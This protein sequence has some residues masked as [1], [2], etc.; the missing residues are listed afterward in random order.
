MTIPQT[1]AELLSAINSSYDRLARDLATIPKHL[2][3]DA[4]LEGHA[5][6]SMMSVRDLVSYL[7]GWNE[8]VL[9]WH[10]RKRAGET[11]DFPETGFKWNELGKLAQKFYGDYADLP[12][13]T[14]LERLAD[15][16]ARIVVLVESYSDTELYGS[17]WY[18][19]YAMGR[20]IQFNSSA[21]YA[22]ARGRLRKW[23]KTKGLA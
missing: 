23:K 8:L 20:M 13:P 12:F 21:P 2:A 19:K 15:T 22:N 16:K 18:E 14:L 5:K 9:K 1:K 6:G 3:S 7:I 10:A 17:P 4:K 11:G